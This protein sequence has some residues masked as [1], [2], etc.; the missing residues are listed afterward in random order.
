MVSQ[1][2]LKGP[3]TKV[4]IA[5]TQPSTFSDTEYRKFMLNIGEIKVRVFV[6]I[7]KNIKNDQPKTQIVYLV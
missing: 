4:G 2:H 5:L 7:I 1:N 3:V 6:L